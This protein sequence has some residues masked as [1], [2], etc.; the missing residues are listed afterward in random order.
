MAAD[1]E[2]PHEHGGEHRDEADDGHLETEETAFP[3]MAARAGACDR[4]A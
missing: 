2:E 4:A 1:A 3:R